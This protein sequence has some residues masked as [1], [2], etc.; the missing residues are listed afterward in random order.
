MGEV[1]CYPALT[2]GA[3]VVSALPGLGAVGGWAPTRG[4]SVGCAA[5][6]HSAL[7]A[8]GRGGEMV[9]TAARA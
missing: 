6:L 4:R 7:G 2:G 9:L 1:G 3:T 5:L 8:F